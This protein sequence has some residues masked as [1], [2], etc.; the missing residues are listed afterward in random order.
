MTWNIL[1]KVIGA[2]F[3]A[4]QAKRKEMLANSRFRALLITVITQVELA[5]QAYNNDREKFINS[6]Q[7][8]E[9]ALKKMEKIHAQN[10]SGAVAK[11]VYVN[12]L[13]SNV[14]SQMQLKADHARIKN[15]LGMLY[16]SLGIPIAPNFEEITDP[17][18]LERIIGQRLESL[19]IISP[20]TNAVSL[21]AGGH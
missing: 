5:S 21:S 19:S 2:P 14:V 17:I 20:L 8:N 9:I 1:S 10:E 3:K 4:R 15:S 11:V 12:Q 6:Y 7:K 13:M 16:T 18:E